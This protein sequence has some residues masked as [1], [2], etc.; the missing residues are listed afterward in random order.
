MTSFFCFNT[1]W[2]IQYKQPNEVD[3][4]N[5]RVSERR[6]RRRR[7]RTQQN[8]KHKQ[9]YHRTSVCRQFVSQTKHTH[10]SR[11]MRCDA[12]SVCIWLTIESERAMWGGRFNFISGINYF[13]KCN[14][15][16]RRL[17]ANWYACANQ[18]KCIIHYIVCRRRTIFICSLF[19]ASTHCYYFWWVR[20][21]QLQYLYDLTFVK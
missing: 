11:A 16:R 8:K 2:F 19:F 17:L 20:T 15:H 1:S 9:E 10:I 7:R 21:F 14:S 12:F 18:L 13:G 6:R 4:Q 5:V 3:K